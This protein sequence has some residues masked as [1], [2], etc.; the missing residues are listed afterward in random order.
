MKID[1]TLAV[2]VVRGLA[3]L[4]G[5]VSKDSQIGASLSKLAD[6]IEAGV[7]VDA[8]MANV[9]TALKS[10]APRDWDEVH[11]R[12]SSDHALLQSNDPVVASKPA[13]PADDEA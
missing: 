5:Q 1:S 4:F 7:N 9:A 8:H 11:S 2:V 6:G 3:N 13:T 12:I 10:G